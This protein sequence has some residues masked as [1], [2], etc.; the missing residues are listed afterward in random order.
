MKKS[1]KTRLFSGLVALCMLLTFLPTTAFAADGDVAKI[2]DKTYRS[3]DQAVE[4]AAEGSTI[5]LL[6][7]CE[8]TKGFNKTLTFTGN[9]KITIDRQLTSDGQ[10]WMC[11]GLYNPNRELTFDGSDVSVEWTS[12]VGTTPWLMLS[13][14]GKLNVTNG[15]KVTF[16]VDSGSAGNRNAIYMNAGSSIN[17]SNG[18][19]FIISGNETEGKEGQ[20]LQLDAAG[21]ANV[22]VT[23]GS[24]FLIDGT[25][26]GYVNSPVVYVENSTFTVQ[27]CTSN[28]SN[29][30]EFT[31]INSQ[32][33]FENNNGHG[34]SASNLTIEN[35][36]LNC[37]KN[38]YYGITYSGNMTM[39]ETSVINANEN[40]YGYTG[41]GLRAYGVS[42]VEENAEINILD[43]V[44]NGIE[45][46]GTFQIAEGAKFT[47]TG[48]D[49]PS[50]NGGG[51]YNGGTLVL[52]STA[53]IMN[54]SA[55]QTGGG[56][57]NA[58]T[59]TIPAGVKLYNNHAGD[60]GDDLYN[61][62]GATAT[63]TAVGDKWVL[64]DC[65]HLIDGWYDDAADARW[66]AHAENA[67]ENH[68]ELYEVAGD[69]TTVSG[70]TAL[71]AAHGKDPIDKTSFPGLDKVIVT[72]EGDKREDTAAAGDDVNFKLTSNVPDDLLNY[73]KPEDA[74]DPEVTDPEINTLANV[75]LEERGKYLLTFHDDMD[76]MF[77]DPENFVVTLDREGTDNDVTLDASQYTFTQPGTEADEKCDFE[78]ALDLVALYEDGIITDDDVKNATPIVVTYTATLSEKATAGNYENAAWVT[79]PNGETEKSIVTIKTYR[80]DVFKYDQ[81]N[82]EK[83]LEGATFE[84][85]QKDEEGNPVGVVEWKSGADGHILIDGLDAGVYYLKETKEPEGYICSDE[86]LTIT[87][88]EQADASNVVTVKFAN[89]PVPHTGG[90]GTMMFTVGGMAILAAAGGVMIVPRKFRKK[91]EEC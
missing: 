10:E 61:R 50:T 4:E 82:A 84:F 65:D 43:N 20:A 24:K 73:I 79:Y 77:V 41:G 2:G 31:A 21:T 11:F 49:E 45:N 51:I 89:S 22:N 66:E 35:S 85:Y 72:E 74:K 90:M 83:G 38:A 88:P 86:E 64:D 63:L 3:L 55:A 81:T 68:I 12:E 23:G 52:P 75:P 26:R 48:N 32:I 16:N 57:C 40:G 34:L 36:R 29:G 39:D 78:I 25:N 8:L 67:E 69:T 44:R 76:D 46:Y 42:T 60:A 9:G 14:S 18:A 71:K 56:I 5:T 47:V 33:T 53:V 87:I 62:D 7:D 27:N 1:M 28:A 59:V 58:G 17:V 91:E 54:N 6:Q 19:M 15:A 70:V 37:N 13:L 30:G 80:I